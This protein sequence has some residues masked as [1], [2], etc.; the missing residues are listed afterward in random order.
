MSRRSSRHALSA[1]AA[2][3]R[4]PARAGIAS[5]LRA[6]RADPRLVVTA[7][8]SLGAGTVHGA[9]AP[10]HTDWWAS[11][12]FFVSLATFQIGW[13][14]YVLARNAAPSIFLLGAG[15]NLLAVATWAVS[16]TSGLPFGPE[17]G[18]AES[19]AR[20]DV[21]AT[22]L[23]L[24]VAIGA[25]GIA[26]SWRR[27]PFVHLC[28][29][30]ASGAGGLAVSA[31]S[32]VALTGVSGHGH[33]EGDHHGG[34]PDN[35]EAAAVTQQLSPALAAAQCRRTAHVF[36]DA[37]FAKAAAAANGNPAAITKAERAAKKQL[38]RALAECDGA[39]APVQAKQTVEATPHP[40]D[41][42]GH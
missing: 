18:T 34:N 25:L 28:P 24:A 38:K 39:P 14:L 20:A 37:E 10:E 17:Q 1:T 42:H 27:Y 19:A 33:S 36:S 4:P 22:V 5:R 12:A 26:R 13:A 41:G 8:A 15:A 9:V 35:I 23:G 31:L 29:A 16:R 2:D 7:L 6:L 3:D 21:I 32:I 11:V 30:L 40:D